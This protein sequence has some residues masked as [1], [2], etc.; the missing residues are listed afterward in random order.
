[1]LCVICNLKCRCLL[2]TYMRCLQGYL[3][4]IFGLISHC[5]F[6]VTHYY[7]YYLTFWKGAPIISKVRSVNCGITLGNDWRSLVKV[8]AWPEQDTVSI[9]SF[10]W[11]KD[12]GYRR[13]LY[14][15]HRSMVPEEGTLSRQEVLTVLLL[16]GK[17]EYPA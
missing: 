3:R 2:S 10:V 5:F 11:P 17:H 14:L 9:H 6:L 8:V 13:R 15:P 4:N 1:V 12:T 16:V 7:Y